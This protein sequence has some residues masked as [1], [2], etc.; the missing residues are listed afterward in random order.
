MFPK[1][2]EFNSTING[3]KYVKEN[4]NSGEGVRVDKYWTECNRFL[5]L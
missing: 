3:V 5:L 2:E 4:Q 1:H